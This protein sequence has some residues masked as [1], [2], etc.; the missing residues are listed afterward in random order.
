MTPKTLTNT[1]GRLTTIDLL[2]GATMLLMLLVNDYAGVRG[3]PHWFYHAASN[4]DMLGIS[5]IVFPAFLFALGLSIPFA[6]QK[7]LD[8]G[9]GLL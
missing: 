6:L 2:R 5:D 4:E 1:G 3:L 8:R 7:R 9:D